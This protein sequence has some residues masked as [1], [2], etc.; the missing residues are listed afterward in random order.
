MESEGIPGLTGIDT[1]ELTKTLREKGTMLGR[2]VSDPKIPFSADDPNSRNIV[3]EVTIK[4]V[5]KYYPSREAVSKGHSDNSNNNGRPQSESRPESQQL[6]VIVVDC[7][8]KKS[9]IR[10]L[11]KRGCEVMV[12]PSDY[13]LENIKCDGIM[14]SNGPGDPAMCRTTIENVARILI[15]EDPI[16]VAGICLGCQLLALAAGGR[17]YKLPYGHRS[18]NQPCRMVA[19]ERCRITSQNHGYAIDPDSLPEGWKVWYRNLNDDTVEGIRHVSLP[20][21]AVQFHPEASPGPTDVADFF[22][23]FLEV[24]LNGA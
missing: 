5:M 12:V 17:T 15:R 23:L 6:N 1:R 16:P 10:E 20:F 3:E 14:I 2:I 8:C 9:I 7:G 19:T 21:F 24:M 11:V 18:Q 13:D 22:D 4:E